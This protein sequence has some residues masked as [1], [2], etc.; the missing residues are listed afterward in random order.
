MK[1]FLVVRGAIIPGSLALVLAT[2]LVPPTAHAALGTFVP[3]TSTI[4][5][6]PRAAGGT[7]AQ[8]YIFSDTIIK[9]LDA[10]APGSVARLAT[11]DLN[12][13]QVHAA[14]VRTQKRGVVV[15]VILDGR[16]VNDLERD[17]IKR[18]GTNV[19]A[20]R[21]Y[22]IACRQSCGSARTSVMHNKIFTASSTGSP[23]TATKIT[24]IGSANMTESNQYLNWN[25]SQIL[26][27]PGIYDGV[28]RFFDQMRFDRGTRF[29]RVKGTSSKYVV[30][31]WPSSTAANPFITA[32]KNTKCRG[33]SAGYGTKTGRTIIR[34]NM[35]TWTG[36]RKAEAELL[37]A[38]RKQGCDVAVLYVNNPAAF[39][40]AQSVID[41][42]W[43]GGVPIYNSRRDF[44]RNGSSDLYTHGKGM[45]ISGVLWGKSNKVVWNGSANWT[46]TALTDGNEVTLRTDD[47]ATYD[48]FAANWDQMR[49]LAVRDTNRPITEARIAAQ[50]SPTGRQPAAAPTEAESE[51]ELQVRDH[52]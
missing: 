9:T 12:L 14:L 20:N 24:M 7:Q 26:T 5:N 40:M 43:R 4:F 38:K 3:K 19:A 32:L 21:S 16:F 51:S 13:P 36:G 39:T 27:D 30:Y 37:V 6:K 50:Q 52:L 31:L 45:L 46:Y 17:L 44:D 49:R 48:A 47:N 10:M 28:A 34:T 41:I 29:T 11:F 22:A 25:Q 8:Q 15:R 42:L 18:F 1:L 35:F 33:A 23:K 2:T